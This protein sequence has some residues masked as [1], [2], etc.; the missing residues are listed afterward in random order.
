[1]KIRTV[2]GPLGG[3]SYTTTLAGRTHVVLTGEK[4]MTR[5]QR[6][7]AASDQY[8]STG[9]PAGLYGHRVKATYEI[10]MRHINTGNG[11]VYAPCMHP[12]GS[13]FYEYV[14]GS[15]HEY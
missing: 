15:S 1:M 4:R 7:K 6:W 10:A 3:R 2:K 8:K 9:I 5:Q 13:F 11:V 14:E 12:D